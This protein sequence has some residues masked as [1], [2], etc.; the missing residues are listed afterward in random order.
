MASVVCS[1]SFLISSATTAKPLPASPACAASI[2]AFKASSVVWSVTSSIKP[3]ISFASAVLS[4]RP[5]IVASTSCPA[6][7]QR[8]EV[9]PSSSISWFPSSAAFLVPIN[10]SC[11]SFAD[12][13]VV[14]V[15]CLIFSV[16]RSW[17]WIVAASSF[18]PVTISSTAVLL[19]FPCS[20][21]CLDSSVIS[22]IFALRWLTAP[23]I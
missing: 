20:A 6:S 9:F 12:C 21:I 10:L 3:N 4:I 18:V 2:L 5:A 16:M 13:R 23:T 19:L 14:N 22:A 1:A 7:L 11:T 17:F 15:S 8:E